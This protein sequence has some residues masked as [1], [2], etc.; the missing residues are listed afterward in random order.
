M[1]LKIIEIGTIVLLTL[2]IAIPAHSQV[3]TG[4][5]VNVIDGD[6]TTINI[7]G[8]RTKIRLACIDA[9]ESNAPMGKESTNLLKN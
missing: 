1:K 9:M 7:Q 3:L 4:T 2:L 5:V 8:K 6:T